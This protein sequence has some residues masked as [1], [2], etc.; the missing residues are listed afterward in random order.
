ML[1]IGRKNQQSF[2]IGDNITVYILDV[3]QGQVKVGID[4]PRDVKVLRTELKRR[5]RKK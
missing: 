2:K 5:D 4:A 3:D 1:V